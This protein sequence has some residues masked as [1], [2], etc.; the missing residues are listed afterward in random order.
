[1]KTKLT[2]SLVANLL[3]AIGALADTTAT[4]GFTLEVVKPETIGAAV[5]PAK[6]TP[7]VV[8]PGGVPVSVA[9]AQTTSSGP[10]YVYEQKPVIGN[11]MPT[12]PVDW[13]GPSR[14]NWYV[15]PEQQFEAQQQA[16]AQQ[17]VAFQQ[18]V[19][20]QPAAAQQW[21]NPG[22][23]GGVF[24]STGV[25]RI[26]RYGGGGYYPNGVYTV[27]GLVPPI[28]YN[29][30]GWYAGADANYSS[31]GGSSGAYFNSHNYNGTHGGFVGNGTSGGYFNSHRSNNGSG[32][33]DTTG[34][35]SSGRQWTGSSSGG[36]VGVFNSRRSNSGSGSPGTTGTFSSG[37]QGT[38]SSSGG[39]V[40]VF[41]S[42]RR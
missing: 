15:P 19:P 25:A 33:A 24:N 1:M 16:T 12:G 34:T 20:N 36:T 29:S 6:A 8:R 31:Y 40:G 42:K 4:G 2:I 22:T 38:G 32:N 14:N 27:N 23:A 9:P 18:G 7:S 11:N 26:N 17:Q 28:R 3:L 41:N 13:E 5:K 21:S 35:F 10:A 37:R 30:W 39:T